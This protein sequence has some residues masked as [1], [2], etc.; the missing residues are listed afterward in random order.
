[1]STLTIEDLVVEYQ[2]TLD[3]LVFREIYEKASANW[4]TLV[5]KLAKRYYLDEDD[6]SSV[7]H[8]KLYELTKTFDRSKGYFINMLG[9]AIRRG[10][11]DLVRQKKRKD[12]NEFLF[13]DS[14]T[15]ESQSEQ[16]ANAEMDCIEYL[17]KKYDQRQLVEALL[18]HADENTRQ[19]IIAF[20]A[21]NYS[22]TN[23]AK[24]LGT[25]RKTVRRRITRLSRHFDGD[26]RDYF[27]V[28]TVNIAKT[29]S[30]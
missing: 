29:I 1:M 13:E 26:Y 21:E 14:S 3:E 9:Q 8:F 2:R 11:I 6:V 15:I 22:Y 20:I 30:A 12:T 17:Q 27:T 24:R 28:P 4:P 7:A 16:C 25:T 10:C 5:Q 18:A 19:C 23:A